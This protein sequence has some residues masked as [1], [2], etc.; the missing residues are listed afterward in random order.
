MKTEADIR[1]LERK[2]KKKLV[3]AI[4]NEQWGVAQ[5]KK[6]NLILVRWLLEEK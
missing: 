3:E 2:I 4:A 6:N 1:K 5:I